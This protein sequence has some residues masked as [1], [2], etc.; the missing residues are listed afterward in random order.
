[1]RKCLT[2]MLMFV[3]ATAG[4]ADPFR[5]EGIEAHVRFLASDLLEG[6]GTGTRG[7]FLAAEYVAAQLEGLGV[8]PGANGSYFQSIPFRKTTPNAES[9]ITLTR[10]GAEPERDALEIA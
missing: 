10:A 4:A 1:M 2:A 5:P 6:R 7:Y 3:A 9:S 8:E